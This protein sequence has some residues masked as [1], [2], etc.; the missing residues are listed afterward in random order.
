[1]INW[2]ELDIFCEQKNRIEK[3]KHKKENSN[4]ENAFSLLV[5]EKESFPVFAFRLAVSL[6]VVSPGVSQEAI[7]WIAALGTNSKSSGAVFV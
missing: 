6:S 1:M 7:S 4:A 3:H 2:C 5:L